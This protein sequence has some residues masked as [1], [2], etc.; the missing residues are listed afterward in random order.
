V[1]FKDLAK[2]PDSLDV[3]KLKLK[4]IE[5]F[6]DFVA[7]SKF[8]IWKLGDPIPQKGERLLIGVAPGWWAP[9]LRLLDALHEKITEEHS[10]AIQL[11]DVIKC[12]TLE[13]L[14]NHIPGIG[15]GIVT[16]FVGYWKDGDLLIKK[17][18]LDARNWLKDRY[19][20]EL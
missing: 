15:R 4:Q 9:D 10:E 5:L 6:P 8:S 18:G 20:I 11:F 3:E 17:S 14:E 2:N 13:D 16:P 7:K 1:K 19:K 12:R